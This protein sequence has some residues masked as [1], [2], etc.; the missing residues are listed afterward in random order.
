[1]TRY[2]IGMYVGECETD[3]GGCN[4]LPHIRGYYLSLFIVDDAISRLCLN[5]STPQ[6]DEL[7]G[8]SQ[9]KTGAQFLGTCI[10]CGPGPPVRSSLISEPSLL[11][12]AH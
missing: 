1:M 7:R 6:A 2:S 4:S 5:R 9:L 12:G 10:S 3:N 8:R 11:V